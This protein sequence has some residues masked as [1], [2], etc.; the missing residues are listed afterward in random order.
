MQ[1]V[2]TSMHI[3]LNTL[4]IRIVIWQMYTFFPKTFHYTVIHHHTT[5]L[6][7]TDTQ[8]TNSW[9]EISAV[10]SLAMAFFA[11][12]TRL[13][14]LPEL[15]WGTCTKDTTLTVPLDTMNVLMPA[16]CVFTVVHK[17]IWAQIVTCTGISGVVCAHYMYNA[18]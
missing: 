15:K 14:S 9:M 11:D 3:Y 1:L 13:A 6:L 4:F 7:K 5:H 10:I 8:I 2:Q 16:S 12:S 18:M 17:H